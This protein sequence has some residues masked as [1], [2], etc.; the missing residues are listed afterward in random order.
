MSTALVLDLDLIQRLPLPIAQLYRRAH[1]AKSAA[2]LHSAAFYLWEAALKLLASTAVVEFAGFE[3]HDPQVAEQLQSLSRPSLGHWWAI[4]R[5]LIP[6]LARHGDSEY[7][8]L[9]KRLLGCPCDDLPL[10]AGLQNVL[11][12]SLYG[13]GSIKLSVQLGQLI[14]LVIAYRNHE[15]GHGAVGLRAQDHHQQVG[16]ALLAAAG[17]VLTQIDVLAGRKLFFVADVRRQSSGNWIVERLGLQGE[18][19][20]RLESWE[21]AEANSNRLP[22]PERVYLQGDS[23][24]TTARLLHP[25]VLYQ[26]EAVEV[27]FLNGSRKQRCADYLCYTSGRTLKGEDFGGDQRSLLGEVLGRPVDADAFEDWAR[28]AEADTPA[29]PPVVD[30]SRY[31]LGDFQLVSRLGSG[32]MGTVYRAVQMPLGR[33]VA[34]KCL[35]RVGDAKSE[36]RFAREIRVLGKVDHPNLVKV[37]NSGVD[38][39]RWFYAMELVEGADLGRICKSLAETSASEVSDE[40][41]RAAVSTACEAALAEETSLDES[42]PNSPFQPSPAARELPAANNELLQR[43]PGPV[44]ASGRALVD[45]AVELV[46]Q[47]ALAAH[48]LHETGVIHRDIKPGNIMLSANSEQAVLLDLGLAQLADESEG[49]LTRTRQFV[50]TL[51]YASPEQ[52]LNAARLDRRSDVYSLGATLWELLTLRPLYDATDVTPAPQLM[53]RITVT[54]ATS[55][56]KYNPDIPRDLATIVLKCLDKE[57]K[58]RYPTAAEL[59]DDLV[60]WQT[61]Q[62]VLAEPPTLRY[63]LG[64]FTRRHRWALS[65]AASLALLAVVGITLAFYLINQARRLAEENASVAVDLRVRAEEATTRAELERDRAEANGAKEKLSREDADRQRD[66]AEELFAS[67]SYSKNLRDARDLMLVQPA[68]ALAILYDSVRCPPARRDFTWGLYHCNCRREFRTLASHSASFSSVAISPDGRTVATADD[69]GEIK[70]WDTA[71]GQERATLQGHAREVNAVAFSPDGKTLASGSDDT[72]IKLW[73]T[74]T[75]LERATLQ[76]HAHVV[77]AVAFS[78]DGNTL[79]SGSDDKTIKLWETETGQERTTLPVHGGIINSL[80]FSPDGRRLACAG[81]FKEIVLWDTTTGQKCTT[82]PLGNEFAVYSLAFSSDGKT[83][84]SGGLLNDIQLWDTVSGKELANLVGHE[85]GVRSIAF[86]PDGQTL[87]SAGGDTIKLWDTGT[88]KEL[89]TLDKNE[90]EFFEVA[91][92]PDGNTLAALSADSTITFWNSVPG[93]EIAELT[94]PDGRFS[95]VTFSPDGKTLVSAGDDGEIELWDSDSGQEIAA[96]QDIAVNA[97]TFSPDGKTLASGSEDK[98]IRLW[99][100]AGDKFRVDLVGHEGGVKSIA[101]SSDGQTLASG[102]EDKTIKLWDIATGQER[103]TLQGHAGGIRAVAFSPNGKVLASGSEDKTIK[104]WDT[105]TGQELFRLDRHAGAVNSVT[106]SPDGKTLAS[107]SDDKTIKLWET[108]TGQERSTLRGHAEVVHSVVFSSNGQTLASCSDDETIRLWDGNTGQE[109]TTLQGH[110]KV[111]SIAFSL[112]GKT[113]ASTSGGHTITVWR[114]PR[115]TGTGQERATL[116]GH[117][118]EVDA[119]AFSPDGKTLASASLRDDTIK[120]WDTATARER[121]TFPG[122]YIKSFAFSPDG[123]TLSLSHKSEIKLWDTV[124]DQVRATVQVRDDRPMMDSA[125]SPDGKMLASINLLDHTIKLVD[126]A[127]GQIRARLQGHRK[128]V[129]CFVFS[130]DG[131]TLA[132][133]SEDTTIKLW[134]TSTGQERATFEGQGDF[135]KSVAFSSDGRTL[136]SASW[137]TIKLWDTASGKEVATLRCPIRDVNSLSFSPD[138]NTLASAHFN[139]EI[140]LWDISSGQ[141][142]ATLLGHADEVNAVDFSPDGKMLASASADSTIKF[143]SVSSAPQWRQEVLDRQLLYHGSEVVNDERKEHWLAAAFHLHQ[144][145]ATYPENDDFVQRRGR[146]Y[147][148][149]GWWTEARSDFLKAAQLKP[150][151]VEYAHELAWLDLAI[152]NPQGYRNRRQEM[153][154]H[155][156]ESND[157]SV[158]D[159]VAWAGLLL[160]PD[161]SNQTTILLNLARRSVSDY[162]LLNFQLDRLGYWNLGYLAWDWASLETFGAALYRCGQFPEAI[163]ALRAAAFRKSAESEA[164]KNKEAPSWMSESE[165]KDKEPTIWMRGFLALALHANGQLVEG[166]NEVENLLGDAA[167]PTSWRQR[168]IL[169]CLKIELNAVFPN[170]KASPLEPAHSVEGAGFAK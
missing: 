81:A 52:V 29:A 45:R 148:E 56:R 115:E 144:L 162:E 78:P 7:Q 161:D 80:S 48:A 99:D 147:A 15:I 117:A 100:T 101:F 119:V 94:K 118:D 72:T 110:D 169:D 11:Q 85:R 38:G 108:E 84:A 1:N 170:L 139:R 69:D 112:D 116:Q 143:W 44:R 127:T 35:M 130:P 20:H 120:L 133:G 146:C 141:E 125:F 49:R 12:E 43:S 50:G 131:Q 23:Q 42:R 59:A 31:E 138:G 96:I 111:R 156:G 163:Q 22:L 149:V 160:P 87:A 165:R 73:H 64:K 47:T 26:P 65:G 157:V 93:L 126:T 124:T 2:E 57:P 62:P 55:P 53:Q 95:S 155:W 4:A 5:K 34:L 121:A 159:T 109:R 88:Q 25:L 77:N 32:G 79:A 41:W 19:P 54:A 86:S 129:N 153:L 151:K 168:V 36:A 123:K 150:D 51:R 164:A 76:G 98:T 136:A 28:Q 60:R 27:F 63:L 9:E 92:F 137:G 14:D 17:N 40:H 113:L 8:S 132:S 75:G 134:D 89:I 71:A 142:R 140:K 105:A 103:A 158:C 39:D 128:A 152:A 167:K 30:S 18:S 97:L 90:D 102:S 16:R 83:L 66:R 107:G 154:E 166:R 68:Q 104:F 10:A 21:L 70:L 135:V 3:L 24:H 6:R 58:G 122:T 37:F 13:R 114:I 61:G 145:I 91:F 67:A 74:A 106:F 46:R 33:Q 82:L